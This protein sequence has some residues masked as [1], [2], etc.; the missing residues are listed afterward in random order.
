MFLN[1]FSCGGGR[2]GRPTPPPSPLPKALERGSALSS[3]TPLFPLNVGGWTFVADSHSGY[4]IRAY[5]A[6]T[7]VVLHLKPIRCPSQGIQ[8]D[9][10]F[11]HL[12][13]PICRSRLSS[14]RGSPS[15]HS[16]AGPRRSDAKVNTVCGGHSAIAQ[17]DFFRFYWHI[18][19]KGA[20]S[21]RRGLGPRWA[22][23]RNQYDLT[24]TINCRTGHAIR[25]IAGLSGDD[26]WRVG[27]VNKK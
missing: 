25:K 12:L 11:Q 21:N 24:R 2:G 15:Q 14:Q 1:S 16:D 27:R 17:S 18:Q 26:T 8:R 5:P 9:P 19:H 22:F 4:E 6:H 20:P 7:V 13:V 3:F 23:T 10:G